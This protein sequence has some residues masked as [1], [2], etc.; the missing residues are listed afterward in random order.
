M[1][2]LSHTWYTMY[3][4]TCMHTRMH[5]ERAFDHHGMYATCSVKSS[6]INHETHTMHHAHPS[7]CSPH[8]MLTIHH[9]HYT[10]CSPLTMLTTHHAHSPSSHTMPSLTLLTKL[11]PPPSC[12]LY[13]L[14][15]PLTMLTTHPD[16]GGSILRVRCQISQLLHNLQYIHSSPHA[17][18]DG[19]FLIL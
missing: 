14:N 2:S 17:A 15:S 5:K 13:S 8:T 10:P 6:W 18:R 16:Y 9:A 4:I 19:Q 12:S 1:I 7:P 3:T 11:T